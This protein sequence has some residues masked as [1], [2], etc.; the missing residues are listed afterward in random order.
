M[1]KDCKQSGRT[2]VLFFLLSLSF[3][4][5][6]AQVIDTVFFLPDS[7][8]GARQPKAVCTQRLLNKAYI[9]GRGGTPAVVGLDVAGMNKVARFGMSEDVEMTVWNSETDVVYALGRHELLVVDP[10]ADTAVARLG[11]GSGPGLAAWCSATNGLYVA[12]ALYGSLLRI[13]GTTHQP[14]D[15]V[16]VALT[17]VALAEYVQDSTL[18]VA[19]R[20]D[21]VAVVEQAS[22]SVRAVVDVGDAPAA[23]AVNESRGY[24]YCADRLDGTVSVID[25]AGDTVI[26]TVGVGSGPTA[27]AFD[28]SRSK[29]YCA[30]RSAGAVFVVDGQNHQVRRAIPVASPQSLALD[31]SAGRLYV[32]SVG[33]RLCAVDTDADTVVAQMETGGDCQAIDVCPGQ[34]TAVAT[35]FSSGWAV[36]VQDDSLKGRVQIATSFPRDALVVGSK[37]YVAQERVNRVDVVSLRD[38]SVLAGVDVGKRPYSLSYSEA[39]AKVYCACKDEGRVVAIDAGADTALA[40]IEAGSS[41]HDLAWDPVGDK[42]YCGNYGSPELTVIDCRQDTVLAR[43]EV[44]RAIRKVEYNPVSRKIYLACHDSNF[45]QVIDCSTDAVLASISTGGNPWTIA[46]DREDNFV[47]GNSSWG[48]PVI[49]GYGDTVVGEIGDVFY[50]KGACWNPVNNLAYAAMNFSD[51]VLVIDGPSHSVVRRLPTRDYPAEMASMQGTGRVYAIH[52]YSN[53]VTDAVTVIEGDSLVAELTVRPSPVVPVADHAR[54]RVYVL[55]GDA[56][57]VTVINDGPSWVLER[58]SEPGSAMSALPNPFNRSVTFRGAGGTAGS[59]RIFDGSGRL[60]RA[61]PAGRAG[62]ADATWDGCDSRGREARAGVYFVRAG[63]GFLRLVKAE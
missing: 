35:S 24:V 21:V 37:L 61:V 44:G 22:G 36:L 48:G 7:F 6:R 39:S 12:D 51:V 60:V 13:D 18:Y 55:S 5:T 43:V 2:A 40:W 4:G 16:A 59:V 63:S 47:F 31:E 28:R 49:C 11:Y 42:L 1:T 10:N 54:G 45:F 62:N 57:C 3:G 50:V 8:V 17:P 27:L 52:A 20:E 34:A 32:G 9:G 30:C 53:L 38:Y 26:A 25:G 19:G 56:S 23:L 15:S 33:T 29:L 41:P 14:V 58:P 46:I